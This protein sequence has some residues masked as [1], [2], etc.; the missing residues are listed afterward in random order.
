[1]F[2]KMHFYYLYLAEIFA[3]YTFCNDEKISEISIIENKS[4]MTGPYNHLSVLPLQTSPDRAIHQTSRSIYGEHH[5][6][7]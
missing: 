2:I 1:M 7:F 4:H 3:A 6:R 5:A